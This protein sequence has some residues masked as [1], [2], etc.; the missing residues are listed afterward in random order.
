MDNS[1]K[2][3]ALY[4]AGGESGGRFKGVRMTEM[5][6]CVVE[7]YTSPVWGANFAV[8]SSQDGIAIPENQAK[9]YIG[10]SCRYAKHHQVYLVPERFHL[11]GY[12]CMCLISP[13]GKVLGAQKCVFWNAENRGNKRSVTLEAI[14]TEFGGITLAVDV[15]IFRPEIP[16]VAA[17]MG[18]QIVICSQYI[19]MA[20]FNGGM[21]V[22]GVWNA[23]Q[24][25]VLYAIGVSN[26]YHCVCAPR[27]LT[28]NRDGFMVTPNL[29]LPMSMKISADDLAMVPARP[30]LNRRFFA[31]HRDELVGK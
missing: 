10:R 6:M 7:P 3:A 2:P 13:E 4:R 8:F 21:V 29:R 31:L 17:T 15:D 12:Q 23:A 19:S 28:R 26:A 14:A 18:A 9:E 24:S 30:S 27:E 5:V 11:M 16:R 1:I 20:D 25:N 22:S